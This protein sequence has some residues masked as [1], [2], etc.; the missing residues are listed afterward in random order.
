[1]DKKSNED[2]F[3]ESVSRNLEELKNINDDEIKLILYYKLIKISQ[4]SF[5]NIYNRRQFIK[6]LDSMVDRAYEIL[7]PKKDFNGKPRKLEAINAYYLEKVVLNLKNKGSNLQI[8]EELADKIYKEIMVLKKN[9]QNIGKENIYNDKFNLE[10]MSESM[11]RTSI[12][13]HI[14]IFLSMMVDLGEITS[15]KKIS[16]II[17]EVENLIDKRHLANEYDNKNVAI[18]FS[19]E[20]FMILLLL[21]SGSLSLNQKEQEELL[22][23]LIMLIMGADLISDNEVI[24]LENYNTIVHL[25]RH[26]QR[27]YNDICIEKKNRKSE[28]ESL[29]KQKQ[30]LE[31]SFKKLSKAHSALSDNYDSYKEEFKKIVMNS[32][33][34]V[35]L[36]SFSE[37]YKLLIKKEEAEEQINEYKNTLGTLKSILSPEIWK[38][39]ASKLIN[40]SNMIEIEKALI[41]EAKHKAYFGKEYQV[42]EDLKVK[43]QDINELINK[44]TENLKNKNLLIDNMKTKINELQRQLSTMKDVYLDIEEGYY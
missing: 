12:K 3:L 34:R 1:M 27:K 39:Q 37:Y 16:S 40:E 28:L 29:I 42:F 18:N 9:T 19:N 21:S 5:G 23:L 30:E 13:S 4:V 26:K 2:K 41:E 35:L 15:Y 32:E 20:Y 14:F 25:W 22:P 38:D 44:E 7:M 10:N 17:F 36:P 43:I 11:I 24:N 6:A 33:K 8:N 31:I